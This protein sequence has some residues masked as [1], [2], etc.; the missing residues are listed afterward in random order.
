VE[1][2]KVSGAGQLVNLSTR[3]HVDT[4]ENVMIA[5]FA[6]RNAPLTLLLRAMG[7]SMAALAVSGYLNNPHL[8][9]FQG[10]ILMDQNDD[11]QNCPRAAEMTAGHLAPSN[12]LESA[13]MATLQPGEYTVQISGVGGE[14]GIGLAEVFK[15]F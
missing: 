9:L 4:G 3:G 2:Y 1:V 14:A 12:P 5:G 10:S 6:V 15:S 13:T 7:P 8:Q 11:W